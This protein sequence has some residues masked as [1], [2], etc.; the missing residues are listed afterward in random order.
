[1]TISLET[2][3]SAA[4][5]ALAESAIKG[6]ALALVVGGVLA[7]F[8][9]RR[10]SLRLWAWTIVLF[11]ALAMPA[12]GR[13]VP[14]RNVPIASLPAL[15][16]LQ[17]AATG[18]QTDAAG[19]GFQ[20]P[21]PASSPIGATTVPTPLAGGSSNRATD[22]PLPRSSN[23]TAEWLTP[24]VV[25]VCFYLAGVIT[26]L[27]RAAAGWIATGRLVRATRPIED[28]DALER[29]RRMSQSAGCRAPRLAESDRLNVPV[30][31]SVIRPIVVLPDS[32]REWDEAMLEAVLSHEVA[33][34]AR[35]DAVTQRVALLYRAIFWFNP[36][37]W[38]LP[39]QLMQ[40]AEQASDEAV[41]A[42]GISRTYYARVL[43]EFF[44]ALPRPG[45]RADWHVA[46]A[47][48]AAADA[49]ARVDRILAWT[50]ARSGKL[51]RTAV[52]TVL[53]AAAPVVALV[54]SVRP[55]SI[56]PARQ[57]AFVTPLPA[58]TA[59]QQLLP[60]PVPSP[61][62]RAATESALPPAASTPAGKAPASVQTSDSPMPI[63]TPM[64]ILSAPLVS[65]GQSAG[66]PPQPLPPSASDFGAGLYRPG[67]G[68]SWPQVLHE[69][70][71]QYSDE[72]KSNGIQGAVELDV[73][74]LADGSVGP[75]RI[76]KSLDPTYGLD[77]EAVRAARQW[78]FKPAEFR[79]QPVPVVVGLV[80]EFRLPDRTAPRTAVGDP[81]RPRPL[82]DAFATGAY[83]AIGT[84]KV[85]PQAA[86]DQGTVNV[87]A[88]L[89]A[90]G[91]IAKA[92]RIGLAAPRIRSQVA[93][94]YTPDAMRA[95]IQGVVEVEA[96]V[97]PD[98]TVGKARVVRSLDTV[99]G[100]DESALRAARQSTFVPGTLEGTPVPVL[101]TM[102][103]SFRLH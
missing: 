9:V 103:F 11:A 91:T 43:L 102:T 26:L 73:V 47:R 27:G 21:G 5:A 99:S 58:V 14:S 61:S 17:P 4:L 90:D 24:V 88:V 97:M 82:S 65:V 83:F 22:S 44:G 29:L 74:V 60:A 77:N 15:A 1:M 80:L 19:H 68:I 10:T 40:L 67:Q 7:V 63:P 101:V 100:L 69:S 71:P 3:S 50:G 39:R 78:V 89:N 31:M 30:T 98:G 45:Y 72:A 28:R 79:G 66:D 76:L 96:I 64:P 42:A 55:A 86:D 37:A 20:H 35:R 51:T 57:E 46:M 2:A 85:A 49:E 54:A 87:E 12:L 59:P 53:F 48:G 25:L 23:A 32:W 84:A 18:V 36:L 95:K 6:L 81:A 92:Q 38:G 34:V 62:P 56:A 75:V 70:K 94:K 41:L 16:W 93:A 52:V 8:L 33:H 13:V